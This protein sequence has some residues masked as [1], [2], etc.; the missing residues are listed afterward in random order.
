M[1]KLRN[2]VL[3]I[4]LLLPSPLLSQT[5]GIVA[6]TPVPTTHILAIGR[7]TR[8]PT[9]AELDSLLPREVPDTLRLIL[10]GKIDQ[11]W[12]R[13]DQK[14]VIFLMN[15]STV[16]EAQAVLEKLPLGQAKLMAF[17]LIPVGPLGPLRMLL[18]D[19]PRD[20]K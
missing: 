11:A 8:P 5:P 1:D 7:F 14:G 6:Q 18:T 2:L 17:D 9:A 12:A 3:L 16:K 10:A 15:V 19:T 4:A 20:K 13:Q